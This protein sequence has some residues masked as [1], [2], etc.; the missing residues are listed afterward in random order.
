[1]VEARQTQ[2]PPLQPRTAV[3]GTGSPQVGEKR[4]FAPDG[5]E[6]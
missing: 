6:M 5:A 3:G 4:H 1:M 2:R